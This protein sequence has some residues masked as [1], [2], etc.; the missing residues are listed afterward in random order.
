MSSIV[1]L[2]MRELVARLDEEHAMP[3]EWAGAAF[4][5]LCRAASQSC[6]GLSEKR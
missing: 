2:L 5:R 1:T 3:E 6:D 4:T